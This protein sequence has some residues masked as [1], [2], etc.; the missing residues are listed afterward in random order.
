M[1]SFLVGVF[2]GDA[3]SGGVFD[4]LYLALGSNPLG[5]DYGSRKP[6]PK[7]KIVFFFDLDYETC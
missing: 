1:F 2:W 7:P 3:T 5:H 4:Y 6:P